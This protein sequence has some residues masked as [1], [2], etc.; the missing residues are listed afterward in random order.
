MMS[1]SVAKQTKRRYEDM[2]NKTQFVGELVKSY[3]EE[4]PDVKNLTL[5]RMIFT[6]NKGLWKTVDAVRSVI[7]N[8]RGASGDTTRAELTDR[9]FIKIPEPTDDNKFALPPADVM[10]WS[11]YVIPDSCQKT[12]FLSDIHVP[13]QDNDALEIAIQDGIDEGCDSVILGGDIMDC[14]RISRFSKDPNSRNMKEEID[15]TKH[16]FTSLRYNAFTDAK[17]IYKEGNHE[18]RLPLYGQTQAPELFV[19]GMV[20]SL[21]EVLELDRFGIKWIDGKRPMYMGK[22]NILH[23]D[24][25]GAKSGGVNPARSMHL[26]AKECCIGG[27]W[28]RTTQYSGKTIRDRVISSWSVGCLCD[29]HPDYMPSNEWNLGFAIIERDDDDWFVVHNKRIINNKVV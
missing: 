12:L 24:E 5:A 4:Y 2:A 17:I 28:H 22:L 15:L 11:P 29:M 26:K 13:F 7:R 20:K 18:H 19:A 10:E 21:D 25:T 23:G 1:V 9:R 3:L 27:H 14:L 16:L 6:E 8:Y